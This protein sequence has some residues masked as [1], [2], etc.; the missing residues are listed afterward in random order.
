[1]I[2]S[3]KIMDFQLWDLVA[4]AAGAL[5]GRLGLG[6]VSPVPVDCVRGV[7]DHGEV[8][9]RRR[10]RHMRRRLSGLIPNEISARFAVTIYVEIRA[11][12]L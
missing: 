2:S 11:L 7:C 9:R 8:F 10:R 1:M 6:C 5:L 3:T 12:A 4:A